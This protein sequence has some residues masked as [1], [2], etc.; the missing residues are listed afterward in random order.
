MQ[1]SSTFS[2]K[3]LSCPFLLNYTVDYEKKLGEG[4]S[5][6][7][8]PAINKRNNEPCAIKFLQGENEDFL[9]KMKEIV[10]LTK[11]QNGHIIKLFENYV[12][13]KNNLLIFSMEI[14]KE[15][16]DKHIKM[17]KSGLKKGLLIQFIADVLTGLNF[18]HSQK[19]CHSD[20]KPGN[21]LVFHKNR[22]KSEEF[23]TLW[24]FEKNIVYKLADWGAGALEIINKTMT[25]LT[26]LFKTR[27]YAA[28]ELSNYEGHLKLNRIKTDIYSFGLCILFCCGVDQKEFIALNVSFDERKHE[29]DLC[30]LMKKWN[31]QEKYGEKIFEL[32]KEMLQFES[33][34]RIE[35]SEIL[36]RLKE[37][38]EEERNLCGIC[39]RMHKKNHMELLCGH[40]LGIKC[41][42][43]K[44]LKFYKKNMFIIP[45]CENTDCLKPAGL[46][47]ENFKEIFILCEQCDEEIYRDNMITLR[48]CGHNLC[49]KCCE[50]ASKKE[51][52]LMKNA[53]F[54]RKILSQHVMNV[55]RKIIGIIWLN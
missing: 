49:A 41:L 17:M 10:I 54:T 22:E 19:I 51:K 48:N 50:K 5:G 1:N 45:K 33:K 8:Y 4:G 23:Q 13:E 2:S 36:T 52:C 40:M 12:D 28:P 44:M 11:A 35:T 55:L 16:L 43:N 18:S 20:I 27:A 34:N 39:N 32:I 42:F 7:V 26:D 9:S 47:L 15:S 46:L 14:A 3:I 30:I 6:S 38:I 24:T 37:I 25:I 53:W 29:K 31:I 21:I